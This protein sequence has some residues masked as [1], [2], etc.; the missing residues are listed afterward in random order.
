MRRHRGRAADGGGPA[1]VISACPPP[2]RRGQACHGERTKPLPDRHE[3]GRIGTREPRDRRARAPGPRDQ[4]GCRAVRT[5][6]VVALDAPDHLRPSKADTAAAR[7]ATSRATG[8]S[9]RR[10]RAAQCPAPRRPRRSSGRCSE[11]AVRPMS[12]AATMPASGNGRNTWRSRIG[13]SIWL[14]RGYHSA[15]RGADPLRQEGGAHRRW[16]TQST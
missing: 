13:L 8:R 2:R 16:R 15:R 3:G 6:D 12:A 14:R 4:R 10:R 11:A 5:P 7:S 1:G 9:S